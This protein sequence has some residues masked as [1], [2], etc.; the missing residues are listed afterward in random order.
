MVG[1]LRFRNTALL[2]IISAYLL[3]NHG[4]MN[5]RFPPATNVGIPLGEM[6]LLF[7]L[8]TI[9]FSWLLKRFSAGTILFPF[10][11]WWG[12]GFARL[13]A[14]LPQYGVWA[15]RDATH[16]IES[17][18][19]LV[20]FA[21][22]A[23]PAALSKLFRWLPMILLASAVYAIGFPW[24]EPLQAFSPKLVA[25]AG[26]ETS[27]LF[28]YTN[29]AQMLLMGAAYLLLFKSRRANTN[30]HIILLATL[31]M[32]FAT[33]IFQARTAYLQLVT[34]ILFFLVYRRDLFG[35]SLIS[36]LLVG[37]ILVSM[38]LIGLQVEGRLGQTVS[39]QFLV[40]HVLAIGGIE[41]EGVV[42]AA[43][44]VWQ[45]LGWWTD[46]YDRVTANIG[47]LLFGLGYGFPLIDFSIAGGVA[48]REPHNSYI[49]I[50]ARLGTLGVFVFA[51]MHI[52]LLGAWRRAL[53]ISSR[54]QWREGQNQLLILMV[55]FILIWVLSFGEDG[56][57]KPFNT[58]PYYFFWGVILHY[59]I[60]LKE[61]NIGPEA[62]QHE[63]TATA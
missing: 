63:D 22:A 37:L 25:A 31:L 51:W 30:P 6:L 12:L 50:F 2:S 57:E 24:M 29:T 34:I 16:V 5:V 1:L 19:I 38:P 33:F 52:A 21:F 61:G 8:F 54:L 45:R 49:S 23:R 4:F 44:G 55:Y 58:I 46:I 32:A 53:A 17:L 3:L 26:Y 60:H 59:V 42:G 43:G 47:S 28:N 9:N 18:F 13:L 11:L 14:A 48:V 40:N 39:T 10:L 15:L 62:Q 41:N 7:S 27:L 56:F 20:G 35:R 36:L